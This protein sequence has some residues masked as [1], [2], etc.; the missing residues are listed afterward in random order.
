[1]RFLLSYL[2]GHRRGILTFLLFVLIF[3]V[4][5][6]LYHLPVG[7]VIYPALVCGLLGV[8]F[9]AADVR[10]AYH[11]YRLLS[12]IARLQAELISELPDTDF[13]EA[14]GYREIALHL[15]DLH[16]QLADRMNVRY[17]DMVDYYTLW[18]H[19]IKTPIASMRLRLQNEDSQLSREVQED[20]FRIEQYVE[21]VLMFL[22]L[23]ADSTDYVLQEYDLD[24][25]VRQ[26]VKKF[27][28]QFIRRKLRLEYRPLET[29]VLTDEKWLLFVVEQVLSNALKYTEEG[30]VTIE[31]EEPKTLC[32]RDTGIGIDPEDLPRIFEKGYTGGNGRSDKRAS[33]IG[34][35]LCRRVCAN[36]GH[37]I[38]VQSCCG[39]GTEVRIDLQETRIET[40]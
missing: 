4:T 15:A 18:V 38:A 20:L 30:T 17:L 40:E 39:R 5:F 26:A 8:I 11:K 29:R 35:Y 24:G 21:M 37:S 2:R 12:D 27:A 33:G 13:S 31:L 6:A 7:A 28:G 36:L 25:V 32:I 22:R 19:Q 23:D 14:A 3:L 10:R 34:L 1:M 16:R 9:L